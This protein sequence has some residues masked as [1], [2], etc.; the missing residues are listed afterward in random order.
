MEDKTAEGKIHDKSEKQTIRD[1]EL[2]MLLEA[3]G[4]L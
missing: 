1:N 3:T 4:L 2:T